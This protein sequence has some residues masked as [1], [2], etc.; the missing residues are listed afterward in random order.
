M[1]AQDD[2]KLLDDGGE[3]P[4]FQRKGWRFEEVGEISSLLD[5]K[6]LARWSTTSCALTLTYR[7]YVSKNKNK[8]L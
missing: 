8:N 3:M 5:I 1:L 2:P 4:K 7:P 6:K